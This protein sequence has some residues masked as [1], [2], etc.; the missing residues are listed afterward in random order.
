MEQVKKAGPGVAVQ[1]IVK[2]QSTY[3]EA[4]ESCI[5]IVYGA[6]R[7]KKAKIFRTMVRD[8]MKF[9]VL[10]GI[11]VVNVSDRFQQAAEAMGV[12][13]E[14][15]QD[16]VQV[17]IADAIKINCDESAAAAEKDNPQARAVA[18]EVKRG[19]IS[20]RAI[21]VGPER[22][23]WLWPGRIATGKLTLIG[24]KP[25]L[26]KSQVAAF[27][28]SV[29]SK[30]GYWPCDEGVAPQGSVVIFS[31]EDG[32]TDTIVP[33]LMG[34]GADLDRIEIVTGVVESNGR[35]TFDLKAH[36]DLLETK[37]RLMGDVRLIII[38]PI[39]AY[40]GKADGNGNV[41]TRAVLEP[42]A[43][44]ADRLRIAVVAVTHL[45]KGGVNTQGA[46]ERFSGSIAFVAAARAGFVI[47]EDDENDGQLLFLQVKNNIAPK[48][49][50]LAFRLEQCLIDGGI[51]VSYVVWH[52]AHIERTADEA[53]AATE[54]R[55][56]SERSGKDDA[57]EFLRDLLAGGPLPVKEVEA[58]A[59]EAGLLAE[60]KP[61][62]QNKTFRSAL[63]IVGI[64]P[65]RDGGAAG[66]GRWVWG[67]PAGPKMPAND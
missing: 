65:R 4:I 29:V 10:G 25:G 15:G 12:V 67:L 45:N 66:A 58:Q 17:W 16:A 38:D 11:D 57:T 26:G 31:A 55:R 40:L 43:E 2:S 24:G 36:I 34:L 30:G 32:I 50:G 42:V 41:E 20:Q 53:L 54:G 35:K 21:E 39:S 47:T 56:K 19:L 64:K 48:Q 3:E 52:H 5:R 23:E 28:A 8:A 61:I 7:G 49:K 1:P 6:V 33:R 27:I 44:M 59:V 60:G 14:F 46:M 62:G 18:S 9:A 22:I 13:K 63:D 37:V 51:V